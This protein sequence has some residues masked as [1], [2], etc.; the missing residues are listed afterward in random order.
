MFEKELINSGLKPNEAKIYLI[1]V[2]HGA[3]TIYEIAKLSS[4]SRPNIYDIINKLRKKG[5]ISSF[6]KKN[7]NYY[8]ITEP[9]NLV[10]FLDEKRKNLST[11][12]P[13][14]NE[15]F[16]SKKIKTITEIYQGKEGLKL[17]IED[18]LIAKEILIF[19]GV[20]IDKLLSEIT[21]FN[22]E[23][24]LNEKKKKKIITKILYAEPIKPVRGKFYYYKKLPK[25]LVLK[26]V[27]YWIY[28]DRVVLG[29][30]SEEPLF[31]KIIN[32]DVAD[33]FRTNIELIWNSIK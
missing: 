23:R 32:K 5:L 24:Y 30:W 2:N 31:I 3:S 12:I 25:N 28:A 17:I 1:L 29:I 26:N 13:K 8:H 7:K 33:T 14:L 20:D 6:V 16:N 4:I 11:I 18:M 10:R 27:N 19:N 9:N 21:T 22:L 15:L